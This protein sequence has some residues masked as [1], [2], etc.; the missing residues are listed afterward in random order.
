MSGEGWWRGVLGR[1]SRTHGAT[2]ASIGSLMLTDAWNGSFLGALYGG[3]GV[4][5]DDFSGRLSD[6][7]GDPQPSKSTRHQE[8]REEQRDGDVNVTEASVAYCC[9]VA[10]HPIRCGYAFFYYGANELE[11]ND[12]EGKQTSRAAVR[13]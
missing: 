2:R 7:D 13:P 3:D 6:G 5:R 9:C 10:C 4:S 12:D 11:L 8:L 1:P